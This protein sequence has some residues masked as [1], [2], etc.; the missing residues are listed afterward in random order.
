MEDWYREDGK[1]SNQKWY[2]PWAQGA[3]DAA[4]NTYNPV[5]MSQGGSGTSGYAYKATSG[6]VFTADAKSGSSAAQIRTVGWGSSN[7]ASANATNRWAFSTCKHVSA[8]QLFLGNWEGVEAIQ[9]ATPNYGIEFASRPTSMTFWYKYAMMNRNG[10]DNGQ[11]GVA[12]I[13]MLDAAGN[14][15]SEQTAE[16]DSNAN[17]S[18]VSADTDY[19][20]N[21]Q[22]AEK[23]LA[24]TYPVPAAK[25]AKIVVIFKSTQLSTSELEDR[26]NQ[27][28][29]R[30]PKPLNLSN[31]EYLGSSL[32]VDDITLNY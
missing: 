31:H 21:G 28:N 24:L 7:K 13:R 26:K 14:V 17:Y 15:I 22:Y 2:Y 23:T 3:S 1:S 11:K 20:V 16:I 25:A 19:S 10:N 4:W 18:D 32:L 30:P 5:S 6:T 27:D 8:G 9:D 29:M 12:I